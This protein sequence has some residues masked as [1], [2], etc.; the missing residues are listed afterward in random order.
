MGIK[1]AVE[2]IFKILIM[3]A[4]FERQNQLL[5]TL[6]ADNDPAEIARLQKLADDLNMSL[7]EYLEL[8]VPEVE[9]AVKSGQCTFLN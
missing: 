7:L 3:A 4:T 5:K 1:Q 8:V 2:W 6:H 9:Q